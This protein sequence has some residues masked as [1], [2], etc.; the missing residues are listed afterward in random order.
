MISVFFIFIFIQSTDRGNEVETTK[1][2]KGV[3]TGCSILA[4]G[5]GAL[6]IA[7]IIGT[8]VGIVTPDNP[9]DPDYPYDP[10]NPCA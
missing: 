2:L 1:R 7:I 5:F 3:S 9:C 6:G 10:D 8:V 4:L